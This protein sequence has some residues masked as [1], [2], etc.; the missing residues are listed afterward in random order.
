[1][2][3]F[4]ILNINHCFDKTTLTEQLSTWLRFMPWSPSI[5]GLNC[6]IKVINLRETNL[7]LVMVQIIFS[8]LGK[9]L[10]YLSIYWILWTTISWSFQLVM[11]F[12]LVIW[13]VILTYKSCIYIHMYMTP[14]VLSFSNCT[15]VVA[16]L[17]SCGQFK[18]HPFIVLLKS[19][20]LLN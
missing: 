9:L 3:I 11:N 15:I 1:M 8:L 5:G 20:Y 14:I 13:K 18:S 12:A 7:I 2:C 16:Y 19:N 6:S 17:D 4:F 10:I